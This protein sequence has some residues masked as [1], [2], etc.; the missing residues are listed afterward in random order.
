MPLNCKITSLLTIFHIGS[1]GNLFH[2]GGGGGPYLF[3]L[4]LNI[5]IVPKISIFH[6]MIRIFCIH[7]HFSNLTDKFQVLLLLRQKLLLNFI[8]V[9][10]KDSIY[11]QY[12]LTLNNY[13]S[14]EIDSFAIFLFF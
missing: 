11:F 5:N 14:N 4:V 13:L 3:T 6:H 10:R 7:Q 9:C 12:K 1:L 2:M 8:I